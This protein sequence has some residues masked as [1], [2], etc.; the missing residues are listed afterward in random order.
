LTTIKAISK[1][2]SP[3]VDDEDIKEKTLMYSLIIYYQHL[4]HLMKKA[5]KMKELMER[6]KPMTKT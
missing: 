3:L 6:K 2:P 1:T 4:R 5:M